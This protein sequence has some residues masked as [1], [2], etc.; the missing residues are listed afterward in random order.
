MSY[1]IYPLSGKMYLEDRQIKLPRFQRKSTWKPKQRFELVLSIFKNYPIGSSIIYS[2]NQGGKVVAKW[3]LDGRQRRETLEMMYSNPEN[4]YE[5]A[6]KT[7]NF[8]DQNSFPENFYSFVED[9]NEKEY[10]DEERIEEDKDN[11]TEQEVTTGYEYNG[12]LSNLAKLLYICKFLKGRNGARSGITSLFNFKKYLNDSLNLKNQLFTDDFLQIDGKKLRVFLRNFMIKYNNNISFDNLTQYLEESF[13]FKDRQK[14]IFKSERLVAWNDMKAVIEIFNDID[15][16]IFNSKIGII[17]TKDI[18]S[19]D[20]QKIFQLININGT[21]LSASEIISAKSVW[22]EKV[23][24]VPNELEQSINR[25]YRDLGNPSAIN[26]GYVKWDLPA[27]LYYTLE[28]HGIKTI[29]DFT[30]Q[31]DVT[32]KIAIGFKILSGIFVNGVKKEDFDKLASKLDY[33][34]LNSLIIKLKNFFNLFSANRYLRTFKSWGKSLYEVTSEG[35]AL[36]YVILLYKHWEALGQPS[37]FEDSSRVFMK[38]S[39][40]LLDKSIYEYMTRQWR[41]SSDSKISRSLLAYKPINGLF[42]NI[43]QETWNK[44][45]SDII[46]NNVMNENSIAK[47][48]LKPLV[49]FYN[50]LKDLNGDGSPGEVDHIIPKREWASAK[51][52][53]KESI[54]NNLY[55]LTLLPNSINSAKNDQLLTTL[56]ARRLPAL[57]EILRYTDLTEQDINTFSRPENHIL[58]KQSRGNKFKEAY[59]QNRQRILINQ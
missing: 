6:T 31:N 45:I 32:K 25:L 15:E 27:S 21:S 46:D 29:F 14:I 47:E 16:L 50:V 41:G 3:L 56:E 13:T 19:H 49:Y 5:W 30:S 42:E 9:F 48:D 7:F 59:N 54:M 1:E 28:E 53:E 51:L 20:T 52:N 24:T 44:F 38:N 35:V 10:D 12:D 40:I 55:N 23:H 39:F 2:E 58:M 34:Q 26:T 37:S 4:I 11:Q 22:N 36:N 43:P 33:N 18:K 17:E 8:G 57:N